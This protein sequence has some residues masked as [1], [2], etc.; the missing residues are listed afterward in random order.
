[1]EEKKTYT[2]F[3]T[4][5]TREANKDHP[6]TGDIRSLTKEQILGAHSIL[7]VRPDG[8]RFYLKNNSPKKKHLN[9]FQIL[10]QDSGI[11]EPDSVEFI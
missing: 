9:R 3:H 2:I 1:M 10:K 4:D 11:K 7:Y 5:L 8:K 6:T